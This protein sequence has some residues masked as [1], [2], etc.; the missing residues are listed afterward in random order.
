VGDSGKE[1]ALVSV[2]GFMGDAAADI[3][4]VGPVVDAG[5]DE[6]TI[7]DACTRWLTATDCLGDSAHG[8]TFQPNA[9]GCYAEDSTCPAGACMGGDPFVRRTGATLWLHGDSFSFLGPVSWAAAGNTTGCR[10]TAYPTQDDAL[11]QTFDD[12]VDMKVTG[13]RIWA[14]QS[15]AGAGGRDY[16]SFDKVVAYAR[17]A[18]V[19]LI[20]VLENNRGD[21][22]QG[23]QRDDAWFGSGYLAPYGNYTL[24]LVDYVRGLVTHFRDEPTIMAWELMHEAGGNDFAALDGFTSN[25]SSVIR[26]ADPNHLIALGINNGDSPATS[27]TGT[28]SNYQKLH[29]HIDIDLFDVQDFDDPTVPMTATMMRDAAIAAALGKPVFGGASAVTLAGTS[30]S[31]YATRADAMAGKISAAFAAGLVGFLVYDYYPGWQTTG[32]DFD[33]RAE[34]P[35]AGP[36]GILAQNARSNR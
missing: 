26:S 32:W 34:E 3:T 1:D 28:P 19:R 8:C 18:G 23:G 31:D 6:G 14:F 27:N 9:V 13:F 2:D 5:P 7:G 11:T 22:T 20:M 33:G 21:C 25:L 16:S 4:E 24:S 36:F 10:V 35:L 29:D 12:M 30:T 15:Y 17:R